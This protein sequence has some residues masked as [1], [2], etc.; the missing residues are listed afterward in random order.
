MKFEFLSLSFFFGTIPS[1]ILIVILGFFKATQNYILGFSFFF[2]NNFNVVHRW[3][4]SPW[5]SR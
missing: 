3:V 1:H 4:G 2:I 5:V